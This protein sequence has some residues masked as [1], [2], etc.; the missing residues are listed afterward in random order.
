MCN[1]K[2]VPHVIYNILVDVCEAPESSRDAFIQYY[3][4]NLDGEY[5]FQ[6]NLGFGGKFYFGKD[7][8]YVAYYYEDITDERVKVASKVNHR[9]ANFREALGI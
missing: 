2:Y 4:E 5:R 9:L 1:Y 6:G 8:W 7:R 3:V